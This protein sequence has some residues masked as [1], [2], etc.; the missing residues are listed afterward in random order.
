MRASALLTTSWLLAHTALS[1]SLSHTSSASQSM[2]AA[3]STRNVL[4]SALVPCGT[5]PLTGFY[6]CVPQHG[7]N[8]AAVCA[9][10]VQGWMLRDRPGRSRRARRMRASH[11]GC[12]CRHALLCLLCFSQY[13]RRGSSSPSPPQEGTTS[14]R[15]APGASRDCNPGITGVSARTGTRIRV[16]FADLQPLRESTAG[17]ERRTTMAWRHQCTF[18]VHTRTRC[19][20]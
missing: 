13:T 6:R 2:A 9:A 1:R 20:M 18:C 19:G 15:R 17:G 5:Q 16:C 4:G 12:A 7:Y 14:P 3:R 10:M 11:C 8:I